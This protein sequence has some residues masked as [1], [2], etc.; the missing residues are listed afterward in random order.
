VL[1]LNVES[2]DNQLLMQVPPQWIELGNVIESGQLNVVPIALSTFPNGQLGGSPTQ[3]GGSLY[4]SILQGASWVPAFW[5]LHGVYGF[6]ANNFPV[7]LNDLIGIQAAIDIL[8]MLG[9]TFARTMG[10]SLSLDGQSQSYNGPGGNVYVIR[11]GQ[12]EEQKKRL[13]ER[14]KLMLGMRFMSGNV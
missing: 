12:L 9:A 6:N 7:F 10:A 3:G 13:F 8:G 2:S 11:I 14:T 1:S 5:T 4:I